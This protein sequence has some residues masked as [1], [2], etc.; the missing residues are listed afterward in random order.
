MASIYRYGK[1][2]WVGWLDRRSRWVGW[3]DRSK[4]NQQQSL[5][6]PISYLMWPSTCRLDDVSISLSSVTN[7]LFTGSK[8]TGYFLSWNFCIITLCTDRTRSPSP[9]SPLLKSQGY[10]T[11]SIMSKRKSGTDVRSFCSRQ[12]CAITAEKPTNQFVLR[13][14]ILTQLTASSHLLLTLM[15]C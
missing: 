8:R 11:G 6:K 7:M 5:R 1:K 13:C 10:L 3:H 14:F 12:K 2:N 15:V 4:Q 9:P